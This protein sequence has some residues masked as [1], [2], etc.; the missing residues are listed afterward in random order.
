MTRA[1]D[2]AL[3]KTSA[4]EL[5]SL[6][7]QSKL[8]GFARRE[9][10]LWADG[11]KNSD[12]VG[13]GSANYTVNTTTGSIAPV[14][15]YTSQTPSAVNTSF[16]VTTGGAAQANL[17]DGSDATGAA[18]PGGINASTQA[19]YDFGS[20]KTVRRVRVITAAANG[21]AAATTVNIQYSDTSLTAGWTTAD[22]LVIPTGVGQ[23][24]VKD[25]ADFGAHRY[26][27]IVYVSGTT[28]GN[29]WLGELAFS[30][31]SSSANMTLMTL[32]QNADVAPIPTIARAILEFDNSIS[33]VAG[34]D[35]TIELTLNNGANWF[36]PS[37]YAVPSVASQGGRLVV[38]TG[39][40]ACTAGTQIMARIKTLTGKAMNIYA[41]G[42]SFR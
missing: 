14:P 36:S 34:T 35:Y 16:T 38:D 25:I 22:Q 30:I 12:G 32:P 6:A 17:Y 8:F 20:N 24:V 11:Y 2:R 13:S 26:W 39:D 42:V 33:A 4:N 9:V 21:W 1:L 15:V 5:L 7:Y 29:A 37:V 40:V 41:T 10:G 28:G 27:R 3:G 23:A 19:A 18:D 31:I